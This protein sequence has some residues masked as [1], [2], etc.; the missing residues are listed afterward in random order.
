MRGFRCLRAF[1]PWAGRLG[2]LNLLNAAFELVASI[3]GWASVFQLA[4]NKAVRGVFAPTFLVSAAWAISAIG[5]YYSHDDVVSA[6][7]CVT[8]AAAYVVWSVM[9]LHF[10]Q[11]APGKPSLRLVSTSARSAPSRSTSSQQHDQ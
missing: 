7:I 4:K 9:W 2:P 3:F 10:S 6:A 8:R 1:V 5:Y 11:R